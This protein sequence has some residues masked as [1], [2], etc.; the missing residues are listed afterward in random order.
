[1]AGHLGITKP[2]SL[3]KPTPSDV[4]Q[5]QKLAQ[6]VHLCCDTLQHDRT[7]FLGFDRRLCAIWLTGTR[8]G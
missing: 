1:M 4:L 6:Y 5:S 7:L 2:I 8:A 3:A